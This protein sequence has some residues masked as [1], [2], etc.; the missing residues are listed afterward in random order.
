MYEI[1][2]SLSKDIGK[3]YR[4]YVFHTHEERK[5]QVNGFNKAEYDHHGKVSY[6]RDSI[7]IK[8]EGLLK[9][10]VLVADVYRVIL[11]KDSSL[12]NH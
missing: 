2:H 1:V 10:W 6:L 3:D 11:P 4:K 5:S 7:N 9:V 12:H 8:A